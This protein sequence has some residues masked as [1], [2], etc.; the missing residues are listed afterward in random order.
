M[1]GSALLLSHFAYRRWL[2][3]R[4]DPHNTINTL[5]LL[6]SSII[7]LALALYSI[8]GLSRPYGSL[9]SLCVV[10]ATGINMLGFCYFMRVPLRALGS[11]ALYTIL[12]HLL[13]LYVLSVMV[14]LIL[15]PPV[16]HVSES[17]VVHWGFAVGQSVFILGLNAVAFLCNIFFIYKTLRQ[18]ARQW[19]PKFL[20]LMFTFVLTGL[21]G[22]YLYVGDNDTLLRIAYAVL[23][24]GILLLTLGTM[25]TP[26]EEKG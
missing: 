9:W 16:P 5:Y 10:V 7:A 18:S 2:D 26:H 25:I 3:F 8:P 11:D 13:G 14:F 19:F 4:K 23:F 22:G 17:G 20:A 6:A 21:G 15:Y 12:S 1:I 24:G